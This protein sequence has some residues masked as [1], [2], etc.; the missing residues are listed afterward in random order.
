MTEI[1]F[2]GNLTDKPA[3]AQA[4]ETPVINFTVAVNT[5]YRT[6]DGSFKDK[7]TIFWNC[8]AYGRLAEH[9]AASLNKG[10]R[11]V[12]TG[13]VESHQ[14]QTDEGENRSRLIVRVGDIGISLR[15]YTA[16]PNREAA[17]QTA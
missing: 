14:W 10:D 8:R 17:Q 3:A 11:V 1:S 12:I 13:E 7:P 2:S 6:S 15:Y 16:T 9:A 4:G 5:Q